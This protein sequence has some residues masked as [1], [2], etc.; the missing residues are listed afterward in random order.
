MN[1]FFRVDSSIQIGTGHLMRCL[2]LA[3]ALR[4]KKATVSFICRELPGSLFD[5][6]GKREF[7]AYRLPLIKAQHTNDN[8]SSEYAQ[9]L[10]VS[11]KEDA[12]Q[13]KA[14]LANEGRIIDWLVV[15]H[16]ALDSQWETILRPYVKK[17]MAIDDLADRSHDCNLLLDQNLYEN[18]ET[19]YEGLV[20]ENCQKL[21]GPKY[22]LLRSEFRE[23][24]KN[25]RQRDGNVQRILIFMGGAD[26][27]NVT[28]KVLRA[29]QMLNQ[30]GIFI[31]VVIGASNTCATEVRD[32]TLN[33]PDTT[34]H[35][36]VRNMAEL[37]ASAD[38]SIGA[39]GT[40]TWER[41]C[42]GLPSLVITIAENQRDIAENLAQNGSIINLGWYES[43]KESDISSTLENLLA[44]PDRIRQMS[45]KGMRLVDTDG[46]TRVAE[47]LEEICTK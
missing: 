29:V 20:P 44:N 22:A 8:Q 35:F 28:C 38:L 21:L 33:M 36:H 18:I 34:C 2:T 15:D 4:E 26:P 24:R 27:G 14:I 17:I 47:T 9:W 3:D 40:A 31:D 7:K 30:S 13:T 5:F 43:I 41:C 19:R 12:E 39:G 42:V 25:L 46:T 10:G 45:L 37:M 1:I 16:Y 11:W 6:I 23:A 32:Q